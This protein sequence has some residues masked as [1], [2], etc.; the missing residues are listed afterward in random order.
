MLLGHE[1]GHALW[2][3]GEF[4]D[5]PES[6]VKYSH[7]DI[8]NVL[9]DIR[10]ERKIQATYP[11]LPRYFKEGYT[12]LHEKNFF[13]IADKDISE[14]SFLDRLN[15]HA[16]IGTIIDVPLSD[17]EREIFDRA[18]AAETFEEVLS[19]YDEVLKRLEDENSRK[20]KMAT[21][22]LKSLNHQKIQK[23]KSQR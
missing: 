11:G 5:D 7:F 23:S 22:I 17:D 14:L 21:N 20:T 10:I 8:V 1:V 15:L 6:K 18:Y 12:E 13:E 4:F 9:E 16:K 19:L 2:T 3:P